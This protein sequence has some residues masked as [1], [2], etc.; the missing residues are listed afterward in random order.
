MA[1]SRTSNIENVDLVIIHPCPQF[2]DL[3]KGLEIGHE[4]RL[5]APLSA[6]FREACAIVWASRGQN[7]SSIGIDDIQ[8]RADVYVL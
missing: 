3:G 1:L 6:F 8:F 5:L 4:V 7:Q 2:S